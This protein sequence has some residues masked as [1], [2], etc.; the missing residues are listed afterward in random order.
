M[1][2]FLDGAVFASWCT[3]ASSQCCPKLSEERKD[4]IQ[5]ITDG[6]PTSPVVQSRQHV[7]LCKIERR[8]TT[9]I[10]I[11]SEFGLVGEK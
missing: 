5:T 6:L 7:Q 3:P 9:L 4:I 1:L 11:E 8:T 10:F 2:E